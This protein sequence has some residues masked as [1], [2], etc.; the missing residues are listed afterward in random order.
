MAYQLRRY[1]LG[2]GQRARHE[3]EFI[4]IE[5]MGAAL[6]AT[7]GTGTIGAQPAQGVETGVTIHPA[8]AQRVGCAIHCDL[9]GTFWIYSINCYHYVYLSG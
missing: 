6:L 1:N 2:A 8:N 4:R 5:R 3:P 9:F 7:S